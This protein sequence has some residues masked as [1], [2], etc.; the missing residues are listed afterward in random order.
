MRHRLAAIALLLATSISAERRVAIIID[1]SGSMLESDRP[2][3][4][5]QLGQ[6]IGDL[7]SDADHLTVIRLP[8]SEPSCADGPNPALAIALHRGDRAGFQRGLNSLIGYGGDNYFAAPIRTALQMLSMESN[9]QR[10]LLMIAD[11]GGLGNCDTELTAD[12]VRL[13]QSGALIAAINIGSTLGA[14]EHNVAFD[15]RTPA[16]DSEKLVRAVAEVYQ[17][18]LGAKKVQTGRVEGGEVRVQVDAFARSAFLVVAAD[19]PVGKIQAGA[20]NPGAASMDLDHLGGGKSEG[21]DRVTRVYRIVKLNRPAAGSWTFSVSGSSASSGWMFVEDL[22]VGLRMVSAAQAPEGVP[23]TIEFEVFDEQT[24]KTIS[25][26][27]LLRGLD[28]AADIDGQKVRFSHDGSGGNPSRN[29][30]LTGTVTFQ[31]SGKHQF[32]AYLIS[33]TLQRTFSFETDVLQV[34]WRLQPLTPKRVPYGSMT[35]AKVRVDRIGSAA[36]PFPPAIELEAA[37]LHVTLKDDGLNGDERA[38][39]GV[40]SGP[41][42]PGVVGAQTLNYSGPNILAAVQQVEAVGHIDF[43]AG[44]CAFGVLHGGSEGHASLDLSA[45]RVGG[46]LDLELRSGLH[47]PGAAL[48]IDNG[49]GWQPI[50]DKPVALRLDE[51][52][53]KTWPIRLRVGDCAG[54]R[55]FSSAPQMRLRT[56]GVDGSPLEFSVP[57]QVEIVPDSW[58]HCWWPILAVIAGSLFALFVFYGYWSPSRFAARVGVMLSTEED[59]DAEGFFHP[60][61]GQ[62]GSRSGF[63]HDATVYISRDFR[64]SGKPPNALV[65]LRANG[66]QVRLSPYN[67]E[68]VW[69]QSSDG[70]WEPIPEEEMAA[71]PGVKYRNEA[72]TIYFELRSR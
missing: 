48:E 1:T 10:L 7:L 21:L 52:S 16:T 33:D 43:A 62:P 13:H 40:Y 8:Q 65:Q 57:M 39:D 19:G 64:I 53:P 3:Y 69:R 4:T 29:G 67:G 45:S 59:I 54:N 25:D 66:S 5:V 28:V 17:R 37:G 56:V 34:A 36:F 30:G 49:S 24:G 42:N 38:G 2:R 51:H 58:F 47:A 70:E 32:L 11:S 9:I 31:K 12:L 61:R 55:G 22:A 50:G 23:S 41:W 68:S 35:V 27:G 44:P 72:R 71:R 46:W 6:I 63:Y 20:G 15:I 26:L 60:I 14:F 18:F